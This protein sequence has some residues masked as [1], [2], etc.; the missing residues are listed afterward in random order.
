M[1]YRVIRDAKGT[2]LAAAPEPVAGNVVNVQ[3]VLNEG[4]KAEVVDLAPSELFD[5]ERLPKKLFKGQ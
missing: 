3:P 4:L 2:F 5:L 1:K